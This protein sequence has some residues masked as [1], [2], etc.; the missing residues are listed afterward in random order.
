MVAVRSRGMPAPR[1][2]IRG[3]R[4]GHAQPNDWVGAPGVG[5]HRNLP[6]EG[7]QTLPTHGRLLTQGAR[8]EGHDDPAGPGPTLPGRAEDWW[9]QAVSPRQ[10][11]L[12]KNFGYVFTETGRASWIL[13]QVSKRYR[14]HHKRA[15]VDLGHL[16]ALRHTSA[17]ARGYSARRW[18]TGSVTRTRA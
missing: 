7:Q 4:R 2:A 5:G 13:L 12:T 11:S 8:G 10:Q 17:I 9:S 16:H 18:P 14:A 6:A 1:P 15:G 3:S